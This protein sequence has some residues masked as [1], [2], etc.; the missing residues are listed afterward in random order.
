MRQM[1]R[2]LA[3]VGI[4][5]SSVSDTDRGSGYEMKAAVPSP[6]KMG[7]VLDMHVADVLTCSGCW[8]GLKS[9]KVI[10]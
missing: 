9:G 4:G 3:D 8:P 1:A 2:Q 6:I 10:W 7:I 5:S